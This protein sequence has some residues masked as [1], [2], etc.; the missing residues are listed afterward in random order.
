MIGKIVSFLDISPSL[1]EQLDSFEQTRLRLLI[2]LVLLFGTAFLVFA[3]MRLAE[4]NYIGALADVIGMLLMLVIV[5]V[6]R[7]NASSYDVISRFSILIVIGVVS[8]N[9]FVEHDFARAVAW[10]MAFS[11]FAFYLRSRHE[12]IV[13][14]GVLLVESV[15]AYLMFDYIETKEY[16]A[17]LFSFVTVV[18]I[19]YY[20]EHLKSELEKQLIISVEQE[21]RQFIAEHDHLTQLPNRLLFMD[22]LEHALAAERLQQK[23]VAVFFI[24]IDRFSDINDSLGHETGDRLLVAIS[25][26][27]L[28]VIKDPD[29]LA[30]FGGDDFTV[31]L[32]SVENVE[33]VMG[34]AERLLQSLEHSFHVDGHE[35]YVSASLGISIF[36]DDASSA[37]T[38][39][40]NADVAMFKAKDEG[41]NRFEFYEESLT[42]IA[43]KR[44]LL[45]TQLRHALE[46]REFEVYYQPKVE[47]ASGTVCGLEA[48]VRWNHPEEGVVTPGNF[49]GLAEETMMIITLGE[50]VLE[51]VCDQIASWRER[52]LTPPQVSVNLS[53]KQLQR[54]DFLTTLQKVLERTAVPGSLLEFEITESE[55]M[56]DPEHSIEIF[57]RLQ[58]MGA[59]L[60]VD[61][62]G[63]GYSSLAYLKRLPVNTLKIDRSFIIDLPDSQEDAYITKAVLA[64]GH[65]MGLEIVA[66]GV[67]NEA[68]KAF[69]E[70]NGC[71]IIQGHFYGRALPA[72]QVEASFCSKPESSL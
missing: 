61:D 20:Y 59:K 41:K 9:F 55:I 43:Y 14:A 54:G 58:K 67:E 3:L 71:R 65:S 19:M 38:M 50:Q 46:R 56:H 8:V 7:S 25:R 40:R 16:T 6:I 69:L 33:V 10:S 2:F 28:E 26:R 5:L 1:R 49:I 39:I 48:L 37:Q 24:D 68:Q 36:P 11:I 47:V 31:L 42:A 22:R 44:I 21:K 30:R 13:W 60:A 72:S 45:E 23:K 63:T 18:L 66:E 27:F 34:M 4:G 12:G 53:M 15:V 17:F 64:L 70:E 35:L 52:G 57:K 51:M 32:E 62:F 29:T